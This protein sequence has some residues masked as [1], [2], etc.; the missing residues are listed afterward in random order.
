MAAMSILDAGQRSAKS[1]KMEL[2]NDQTW[3]IG[4]DPY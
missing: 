2:A 1:G 3:C 4:D